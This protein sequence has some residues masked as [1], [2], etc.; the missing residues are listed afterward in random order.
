MILSISGPIPK[1]FLLLPLLLVMFYA[2]Q[3]QQ[4]PLKVFSTS[5]ESTCGKRNRLTD[6]NLEREVQLLID[7]VFDFT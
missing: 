3:L 5:S 6:Y 7:P 2:H 1:V 4:L